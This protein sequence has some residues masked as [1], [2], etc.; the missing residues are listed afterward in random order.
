MKVN[1]ESSTLMRLCNEC[2]AWNKISVKGSKQEDLSIWE[3][4]CDVEKKRS[5]LGIYGKC[6]EGVMR[7][8]LNLNFGEKGGWKNVTCP[9][10]VGCRC[11]A[12]VGSAIQKVVLAKGFD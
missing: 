6:I 9:Q 1:G 4:I 10:R 5:C 3:Y 11:R 7:T 12:Q 2:S 8:T